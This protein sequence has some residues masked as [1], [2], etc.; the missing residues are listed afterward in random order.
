MA[1]AL[2][3]D[4]RCL[5]ID[6][7]GCGLS[8]PVPNGPLRTPSI[9][10]KA[11]TVGTAMP[12]TEVKV[13]DP[14]TCATVPIGEIGELCVRGYPVMLGYHDMPDQTAEAIDADGWLHTGDLA[15]MNDRGY[16]TIEG[17]L[18]DM[19]IR[20]GENIY[21]KELEEMLLTHPA[22][23]EVA[24]VR[25]PDD[26]HGAFVRPVR[27]DPE[28][29]HLVDGDVDGNVEQVPGNE[30]PENPLAH[31]V[32]RRLGAAHVRAKPSSARSAV[33]TKPARLSKS[34]ARG[35]PSYVTNHKRNRWRFRSGSSWSSK[36]ERE[37]ATA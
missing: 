36:A 2:E 34:A 4:F 23:A 21:P 17:H 20:G 30:R 10:D 12:N 8:D 9:E 35:R 24:V 29:L 16:C 19:I 25:L 7:P 31:D 33:V 14:E 5:L 1:A 3:D 32:G 15:A 18:K 28:N 27:R 6:R 37:W 13:I 26:K 11:L 22:V